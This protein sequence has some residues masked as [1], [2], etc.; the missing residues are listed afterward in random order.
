M[1][2]GIFERESIEERF[3]SKVNKLG[4]DECWEW[5]GAL[6]G[7]YGAFKYNKGSIAHRYSYML[8]NNLQEIPKDMCICHKCDDP[9]CVNPKHLFIG[10]PKDNV[11][12]MIEKGRMINGMKGKRHKKETLDVL[13]KLS[14]GRKAG[15]KHH[16][17][18]LT[19]EQVKDIRSLYSTGKYIQ[20][21]MAD[22]FGINN[23]A[24]S[25]IINRKSWHHIK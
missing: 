17:V 9:S 12:D 14:K 18:K 4:E 24:I 19:E 5:I 16:N 2:R 22:F 25:K 8:H 13:S 1:P 6:S 10:T 21:S 3:W 11:R 20:Q 23:S 15:I 7:G